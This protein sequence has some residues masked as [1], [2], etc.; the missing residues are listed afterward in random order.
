MPTHSGF[1]AANKITPA[2]EVT[3]SAKD[4]KVVAG[5]I[6]SERFFEE[7]RAEARPLHDQA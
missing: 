6:S 2:D 1:D 5:L 3:I 7:P 4:L